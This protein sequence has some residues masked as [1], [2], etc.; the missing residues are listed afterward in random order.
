MDYYDNEYNSNSKGNYNS[1]Y[2][3]I[4]PNDDVVSL[5]TWILILIVL[6]I[7]IINIIVIL[8]LAFGSSNENLNNFGRACLILIA[9]GLFLGVFLGACSY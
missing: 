6:A 3:S 4:P 1:S 8:V 5:G 2:N 7:P 9:I